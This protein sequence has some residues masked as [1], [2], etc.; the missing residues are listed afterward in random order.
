VFAA[1]RGKLR[2]LDVK[3]GDAHDIVHA[4]RGRGFTAHV[5]PLGYGSPYDKPRL[6]VVTDAP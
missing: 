2:Q 4:L 6:A 1:Q 5:E 3:S